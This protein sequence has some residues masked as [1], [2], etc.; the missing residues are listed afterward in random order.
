LTAKAELTTTWRRLFCQKI[1]KT[2]WRK[3]WD[4]VNRL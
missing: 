4:L 3:K 2:Y 1:Q